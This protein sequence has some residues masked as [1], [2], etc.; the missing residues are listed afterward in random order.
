MTQEL[1]HIGDVIFHGILFDPKNAE[2]WRKMSAMESIYQA[3]PRLFDLLNERSVDY[4]LVGGIAMLAYIEGRNTQDIDLM[5]SRDALDALPEISIA[6]RNA[7]FAQ[8]NFESIRIDI[9]F[10]DSSFFDY[11]RKNHV[12]KQ[13][14][15]E[16]V[17]PIAT[18]EGM[19]LLKLFA[20]PSL[21][22]QAQFSKVNIYEADVANLLARYRIA[23]APL[24]DELA[25]YLLESD[26]IEIRK[27]VADIE[28]RVSQQPQRFRGE[29]TP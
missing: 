4:V 11:V 23:M 18:V 16:R 15:V 27:I 1:V 22:R 26:I 8:G 13:R 29:Q 9:L 19:L 12:A 10:A 25:K 14:F 7:E 6:D 17:V 28:N 21:Y 5:L 3:V 24:L 2:A 20:L